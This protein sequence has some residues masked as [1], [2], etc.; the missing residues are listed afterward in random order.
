MKELFLEQGIFF[1]GIIGFL[2][3]SVFCQFFIIYY[4]LQMVK[5]SEKLEEEKTKVLRD[6]IEEYIREKQNIM[7]V[8]VFINKKLQQL[9][10]GRV[11][12]SGI[13]HF[14]GQ[15]LLLAIF[16]AGLGACKGI[17]E[18]KTLGEVLP[19]YIISLFGMYLHFSLSG[20]MDLEGKKKLI[21]T[22]LTDFLENGK[23]YL[24]LTMKEDKEREIE[25]EKKV[26]G[27]Q[28]EQELREV[29]REILA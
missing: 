23:M 5:A 25:E 17:I 1:T 16:L 19:F 15:M 11:K 10:I 9:S 12:I 29:I 28:E 26:F 27:E 3:I 22:N 20:V 21:Q 4:M 8:T 18:G 24:Y 6:W 7:N 13:K 14:S 2:L